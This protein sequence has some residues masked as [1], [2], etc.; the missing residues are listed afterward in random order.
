MQNLQS[1]R[2]DRSAQNSSEGADTSPTGGEAAADS[3]TSSTSSPV[4]G[5]SD[6]FLP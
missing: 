5:K 4:I 1:F 6:L 3:D 2:K